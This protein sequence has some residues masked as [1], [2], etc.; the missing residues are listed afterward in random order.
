[1]KFRMCVSTIRTIDDVRWTLLIYLP[2]AWAPRK[3]RALR[4]PLTHR[5]SRRAKGTKII[6]TARRKML[7]SGAPI[8]VPSPRCCIVSMDV[9]VGNVGAIMNRFKDGSATCY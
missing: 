9:T 7:F 2:E 3:L 8:F 5:R 1:M 4:I 6:V